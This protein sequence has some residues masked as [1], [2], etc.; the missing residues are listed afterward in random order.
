M[1]PTSKEGEHDTGFLRHGYVG[2][3]ESSLKLLEWEFLSS[4]DRQAGFSSLPISERL[5]LHCFSS[6]WSSR[7]NGL[8]LKVLIHGSPVGSPRFP[9]WSSLESLAIAIPLAAPPIWITPKMS[10]SQEI[11]RAFELHARGRKGSK[12]TN[13]FVPGVSLGEPRLFH[14]LAARNGVQM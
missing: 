4:A 5:N 7:R 2:Q 14:F 6:P 3:R 9:S 13:I 1:H 11:P 8:V 12:K 10:I